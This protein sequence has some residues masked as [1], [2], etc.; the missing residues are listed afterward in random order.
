MASY[1]WIMKLIH[2]KNPAYQPHR[3]ICGMLGTK[4]LKIG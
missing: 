3:E 2:S 1:P 4:L